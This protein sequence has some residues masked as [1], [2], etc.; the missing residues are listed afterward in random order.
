M[1]YPGDEYFD[2]H[3]NWDEL[4]CPVS[5]IQRE[6][7]GSSEVALTSTDFEHKDQEYDPDD[8]G[9][10][11]RLAI[12][13]RKFHSEDARLKTAQ[14]RKPTACVR[15]RMQRIRVRTCFLANTMLTFVIAV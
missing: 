1:I 7:S 5:S 11:E 2:E 3:V 8:N 15:C 12:A 9:L 14:I 10:T 13:R 6:N 4:L